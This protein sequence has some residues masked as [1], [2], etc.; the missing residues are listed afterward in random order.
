MAAQSRVTT[1]YWEGAKHEM[2]WFMNVR[3]NR[4]V[5]SGLD[6]HNILDVVG[7]FLISDIYI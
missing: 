6:H 4:C 1:L 3:S 5:G 2:Y 7:I